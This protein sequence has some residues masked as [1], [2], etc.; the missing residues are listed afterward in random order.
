MKKNS[1]G[2]IEGFFIIGLYCICGITGASIGIIVGVYISCALTGNSLNMKY[3]GT[4]ALNPWGL[5]L[6]ILGIVIGGFCIG[7]PLFVLFIKPF[8]TRQAIIELINKYGG[9]TTQ[10]TG[11]AKTANGIGWF[12]FNLLYPD[13]NQK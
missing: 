9:S 3:F 8:Y 6:P 7:V 11:M 5:K 1:I 10:S 4:P 12:W 2:K 13:G